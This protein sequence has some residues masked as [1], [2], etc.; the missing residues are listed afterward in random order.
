MT[1]PAEAM[2]HAAARARRRATD[3]L[4]FPVLVAVALASF[5]ELALVSSALL[6]RAGQTP[7]RSRCRRGL[8]RLGHV[9]PAGRRFV[10]HRNQ[11]WGH[12][13]RHG[14]GRLGLLRAR[15]G[16]RGPP[17]W[18]P[19]LR[20]RPHGPGGDQ[21]NHRDP[22]RRVDGDQ[23]PARDLRPGRGPVGIRG[24][25]RDREG[26]RAGRRPSRSL[27]PQPRTIHHHP[28][29]QD[30]RHPDHRV[31]QPARRQQPD[32][33]SRLTPTGPNHL[34]KFR[35]SGSST[36]LAEHLRPGGAQNE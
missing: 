17:R 3:L 2:P 31:D 8:G 6:A 4:G 28:G 20:D 19:I 1:P 14:Q 33:A 34:D 25:G 10:G 18:A 23:V 5:L 13:E 26:R 21:G 32:R 30:P 22:R 24:A 12:R 11:R 35:G 15:G 27:Q 29:P 9:R 16:G 36:R 7:G